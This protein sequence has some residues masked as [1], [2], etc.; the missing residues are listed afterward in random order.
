MKEH[1]NHPMSRTAGSACGNNQTR[2]KQLSWLALILEISPL[3]LFVV[4]LVVAPVGDPQE[5]SNALIR[6][7]DYLL[8]TY[9]IRAGRFVPPP[10][11][12][13][14]FLLSGVLWWRHR[15]PTA[16]VG[17]VLGIVLLGF[18][19]L[20]MIVPLLAHVN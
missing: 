18:W 20:I 1:A 14:G 5:S 12:A 17:T 15:F 13:A 4:L 9:W 3:L 6:L 7:L 16:G 11:V 2:M 10:L 8:G 19:C